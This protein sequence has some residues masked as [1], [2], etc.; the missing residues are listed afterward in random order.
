M[1]ASPSV[2]RALAIVRDHGGALKPQAFARHYFPYDHPGWSR[3]TRCGHG[4]TVGGGLRLWAGGFLGKLE[5]AGLIERGYGR[6]TRGRV[7][8]TEAG[9]A[10]L[11]ANVTPPAAG[12]GKK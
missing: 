12:E 4:T 5:H 1:K 11:K 3:H 2:L 6:D 8:L 10:M 9:L 7:W